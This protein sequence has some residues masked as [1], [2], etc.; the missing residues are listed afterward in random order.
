MEWEREGSIR[1]VPLQCKTQRYALPHL[2][3]VLRPENEYFDPL[4]QCPQ[5]DCQPSSPFVFGVYLHQLQTSW[6]GSTIS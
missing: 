1:E 3:L 2:P 5:T 4:V 6:A